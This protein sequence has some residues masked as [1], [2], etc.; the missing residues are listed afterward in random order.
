MSALV[1]T[2]QGKPTALHQREHGFVRCEDSSGDF[3]VPSLTGGVD[4]TVAF[5]LQLDERRLVSEGAE[6][7][8]RPRAFDL[9]V[10]LVDR[11]G[12]LVSKDEL[13]RPRMAGHGGRGRRTA[14]CSAKRNGS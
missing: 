9:L 2:R 14:A 6:A 12:H 1:G 3:R 4:Q 8:L 10:A 5:E 11:A 7:L 13:S